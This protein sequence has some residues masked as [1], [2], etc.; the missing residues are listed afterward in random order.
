MNILKLHPVVLATI[1]F[2]VA[3]VV[4]LLTRFSIEVEPELVPSPVGVL[5]P[6]P[7]PIATPAVPSPTA[8]AV[9]SPIAPPAIATSPTPESPPVSVGRLR[10]SNQTN[11]PI[12][13][14]LLYSVDSNSAEAAAPLDTESDFKEPVH[15][16]FAPLEGS[17]NGL[18][19]S[20]PSGQ[21]VR[22]QSGDV[23]VAF[24]Q[25]GS[26]RYWGPYVIGKTQVPKW[27]S[28]TTEWELVLQPTID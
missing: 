24:A 9:P 6:L 12:R 8:P 22:L 10:V 23:L 25:D 17:E 5:T 2:S 4:L 14:A 18:L 1:V 26:Q 13:V 7:S 21:N 3:G 15:W 28:G 19:L 20:L 27:N 11:H 16:D